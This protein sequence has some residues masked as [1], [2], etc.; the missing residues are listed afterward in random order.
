MPYAVNLHQAVSP[1]S[2][3][4]F[5]RCYESLHEK[6]SAGCWA[7]GGERPLPCFWL[8]VSS[9]HSEVLPY[10]NPLRRGRLSSPMGIYFVCL[11]LLTV[12]L[13]ICEECLGALTWAPATC[14]ES[15]LSLLE[16]AV[17]AGP[18]PMVLIMIA[19][20]SNT[21]GHLKRQG[22]LLTRPG[23]YRHSWIL[24]RVLFGVAN[25]QLQYGRAQRKESSSFSAFLRP[26]CWERLRVRGEGSSM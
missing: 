23:G 11:S 18:V 16:P 9:E 24:A 15:P 14:D 6:F 22:L 7:G 8:Y 1:V 21:Q 20:H 13:S 25:C 19:P 2:T 26:W 4:S 17:V 10:F 5:D 12:M 3:S